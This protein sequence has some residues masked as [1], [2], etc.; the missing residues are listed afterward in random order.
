VGVGSVG[1]GAAAGAPTPVFEPSPVPPASI[2]ATA[3]L[4]VEVHREL[5]LLVEDEANVEREKDEVRVELE[6]RPIV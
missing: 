5:L 2:V 4:L 1:T 3:S 6:Y